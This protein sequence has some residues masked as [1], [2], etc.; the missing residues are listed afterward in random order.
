MLTNISDATDGAIVRLF[1][2][3][4]AVAAAAAASLQ[5]VLIPR[6]S[7]ASAEGSPKVARRL[8]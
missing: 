7:K 5:R 8:A 1:R 6:S 3:P 4:A 2:V